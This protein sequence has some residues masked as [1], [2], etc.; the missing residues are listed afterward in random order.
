GREDALLD[1]FQLRLQCV[2]QRKITVHYA[3][4]ERIEHVPRAMLEKLL[5]SLAA[6]ADLLE[7]AVDMASHREYV[8]AP[9]ED[10][11]LPDA[12]LVAR[13]LDEMQ[14]RE[15]HVAVFLDLRPLVPVPC[16]LYRERMEIELLLH[17]GELGVARVLQGDPDEAIRADDVIADLA[18]VDVRELL[19]VLIRDAIDQHGAAS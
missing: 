6:R 14:H 1:L 17:L 3:V 15:H 9:D 11:H 12:K 7:A 8:V 5:L 16:V 19:A 18:L 4:H 2:E 10:S 13:H